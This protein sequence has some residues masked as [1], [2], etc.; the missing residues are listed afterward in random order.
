[1]LLAALRI[2]SS[3]GDIPEKDA[4]GQHVSGLLSAARGGERGQGASCP[5]C[6][7]QGLADK[8]K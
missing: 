2:P 1:M 3:Q 7:G 6:M 5:P 8:R 4:R